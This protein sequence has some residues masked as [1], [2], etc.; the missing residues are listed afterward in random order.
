MAPIRAG[1]VAAMGLLVPAALDSS[2]A[3][4]TKEIATKNP[5]ELMYFVKPQGSPPKV[6][7]K[8]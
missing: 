4:S 7:F 1:L 3:A 5:K 6:S 2:H 8:K